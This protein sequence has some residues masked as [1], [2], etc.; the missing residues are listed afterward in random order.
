MTKRF[1]NHIVHSSYVEYNIEANSNEL[2]DITHT[3]N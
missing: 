3:S 2:V 1:V